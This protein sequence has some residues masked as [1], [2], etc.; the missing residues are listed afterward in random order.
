MLLLFYLMFWAL[1]VYRALT[2]GPPGV[3][4]GQAGCF[5]GTRAQA[6]V[7]LKGAAQEPEPPSCREAET[8][9]SRTPCLAWRLCRLIAAVPWNFPN[10]Q[11]F[12][13]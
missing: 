11:I 6:R 2:Q 13:M 10:I 12:M 3:T 4:L 7:P 1:S 5:C 9:S 8:R